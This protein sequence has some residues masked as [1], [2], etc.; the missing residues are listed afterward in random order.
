M[1]DANVLEE[2]VITELATG[3]RNSRQVVYSNQIVKKE[4]LLSTPNKNAL[5]VLRGKTAG[6]KF[7]N[8]FRFSW[9]FDKNSFERGRITLL[10]IIR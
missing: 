1:E 4:D 9:S 8:R 3:D 10:E 7:D 2:V 6:V 5:E